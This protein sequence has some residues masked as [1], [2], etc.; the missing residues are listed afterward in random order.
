VGPA[1]SYYEQREFQELA[2]EMAD[3]KGRVSR[4]HSQALD[5]IREGVNV[6]PRVDR[7]V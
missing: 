2:A 3:T 6:R 5:R 7:K 1:E 4:L